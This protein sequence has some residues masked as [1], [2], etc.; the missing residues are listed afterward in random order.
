MTTEAGWG[1]SGPLTTV[2]WSD[3]RAASPYLGGQGR[4]LG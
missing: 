4:R 3:G 1:A 2:K